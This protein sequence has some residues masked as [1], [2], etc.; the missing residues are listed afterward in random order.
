L[1]HVARVAIAAVAAA[2]SAAADRPRQG[3]FFPLP[4]VLAESSALSRLDLLFLF[5]S[6][7]ISS[8]IFLFHYYIHYYY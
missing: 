5:S 2:V 7:I 6:T 1:T 3:L 4:S 8:L